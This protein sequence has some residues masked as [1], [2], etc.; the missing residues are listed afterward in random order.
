MGALSAPGT[1][2]G[3]AY[4]YLLITA[5]YA[6]ALVTLL[7]VRV[8][9]RPPP[10]R[11]I[12]SLRKDLADG[13]RFVA[14]RRPLALLLACNPVFALLGPAYFLLLPGFAKEVLDAGPGRLGLLTSGSGV[15]AV[16]GSLA[17]A[18]LPIRRRGV[19]LL[20]STVLLGLSLVAFAASTSY[21]LSLAII[22]F[23]GVGQAGYLGLMNVLVQTLAGTTHRGRVMS[24]YMME[25]NVMQLLLFG[26]RIATSVYGPRPTVAVVGAALAVLAA[27]AGA[28]ADPAGDRAAA[29]ARGP[30]PLRGEGAQCGRVRSVT[31]QGGGGTMA[32]PRKLS[33]AEVEEGLA[34]L[35]GWRLEGGDIMRD[36][37]LKDFV[38]AA[39]FIAQ[40]AVLAERMNH[41]PTITNTYNR[42][43]IALSTH[44]VDGISD[45]D[46]KLAGEIS[47]R[48]G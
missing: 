2:E 38:A 46:L 37:Q 3:A 30:R 35:A 33:D 32:G 27:A 25:F 36:F 21:W 15:G 16:A 4:V 45:F 7:P 44:D 1:I 18:S 19:L 5:L 39:G 40:I 28:L 24:I 10:G 17:V 42:V 14:G 23:V 13:F 6:L 20:A 41:H 11:T 43:G 26:M 9:N 22:L 29:S 31:T 47:E 12:A 8:P 34:G 48:A